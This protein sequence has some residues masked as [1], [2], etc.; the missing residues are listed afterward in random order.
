[1]GMYNDAGFANNCQDDFPHGSLKNDYLIIRDSLFKADEPKA[2]VNI[3]A[4]SDEQARKVISQICSLS[5]AV[6][7]TLGRQ[8]KSA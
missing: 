3:A 6:A 4:R 1:M 5:E 7:Y 8:S 2:T